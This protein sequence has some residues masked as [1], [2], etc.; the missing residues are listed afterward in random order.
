M[1]AAD[2]DHAS[3]P[4][5]VAAAIAA[6]SFV[7]LVP[8]ADGDALAAAGLLARALDARGTPFQVSVATPH[9]A[10]RATD[11]DRTVTVGRQDPDADVVLTGRPASAAAFA[12]AET[13][14]A[15]PDPV[16]ALAGAVA[17]GDPPAGLVERVERA[18]VERRPGVAVPTADLADGLAGSTLFH[19]PFSGDRAAAA[20]ALAGIDVDPERGPDEGSGRRVA[21]LVALAVA[22]DDDAAP[23]AAEAV[24]RALRPHVGGPFVTVGGYA[25]VLDAVARERPGLGVALALGHD[26]GDRALP[27]WRDHAER[28]HAGVREATTGRYDGLFVARGTAIPV[29]TVARLVGDL[30]SPEPATLAVADGA[31]ALYAPDAGADAVGTLRRAAASVDGTAGADGTDRR[32]R[33]RFETDTAS[34]IEATREAL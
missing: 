22:G 4:D 9:G 25:D 14:E 11:A 13:L 5:D 12:A 34:F 24:E 29:G 26:V 27:V 21:S 18:G 7:R 30:R 33:A 6:A 1:S 8:R 15:S 20:D 3:A 19:A 17:A 28:A 31:A 32:A 10:D 16:L 23:S 2:R